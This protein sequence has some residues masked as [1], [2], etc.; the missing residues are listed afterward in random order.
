MNNQ[1]LRA[2]L[3]RLINY[4]DELTKIYEPLSQQVD[5]LEDAEEETLDDRDDRFFWEDILGG[6]EV[7]IE[8]LNGL[9][10]LLEP[11]P[12]EKQDV[13]RQQ[14]DEARLLMRQG[15]QMEAQKIIEKLADNA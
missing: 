8:D 12:Q 4:R 11:S 3:P 9:I 2:E 5:A 1:D 15:R 13:M 14:L 7:T 6:L 10:R